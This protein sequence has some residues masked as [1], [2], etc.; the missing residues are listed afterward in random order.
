MF[1]QR[2]ETT[3]EGVDAACTADALVVEGGTIARRDND[4]IGITF[5]GADS[6]ERVCFLFEL[7]AKVE[8][9]FTIHRQNGVQWIWLNEINRSVRVLDLNEW[10]WFDEKSGV[11]NYIEKAGVRSPLEYTDNAEQSAE[12]EEPEVVTAPPK[13]SAQKRGKVAGKVKR[14]S[15]GDQLDF[16]ALLKR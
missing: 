3:G 14:D 4:M 10:V 9:S 12:I 15:S 2:K 13:T 8:A 7:L 1:L 5:A 16:M 6:W 11:I